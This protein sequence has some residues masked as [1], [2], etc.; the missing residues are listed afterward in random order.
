MY[1]VFRELERERV[2][3]IGGGERGIERGRGGIER[4]RG[5]VVR[6]R[7]IDEWRYALC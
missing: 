4:E 2:R 3:G 1:N 6:G 7:E 5:G